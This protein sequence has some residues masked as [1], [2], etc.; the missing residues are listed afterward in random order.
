MQKHMLQKRIQIKRVTSDILECLLVRGNRD[1]KDGKE[2]RR[3][4]GKEG[5][6][7][8]GADRGMKEARSR[9]QTLSMLSTSILSKMIYRFNKILI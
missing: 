7:E 4:K 2:G 9:I 6:K 1:G 8:E 5:T 3:E